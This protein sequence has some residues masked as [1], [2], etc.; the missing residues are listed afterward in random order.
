MGINTLPRR[1][2]SKKTTTTEFGLDVNDI[3]QLHLQTSNYLDG[4]TSK[5]EF[6]CDRVDR[7]DRVSSGDLTGNPS[8][9]NVHIQASLT[10]KESKLEKT[11]MPEECPSQDE[12]IME[13]STRGSFSF[14]GTKVFPSDDSGPLDL[15]DTD[16]NTLTSR[17]TIEE[18]A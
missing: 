2:P 13:T 15:T 14:V 16:N 5:G 3:S 8:L 4:R 9:P 7:V 1:L 12:D 6:N 18:R 11:D 17:P 10:T